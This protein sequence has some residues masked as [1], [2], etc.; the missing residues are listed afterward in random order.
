MGPE[1]PASRGKQVFAGRN[2]F[3]QGALAGLKKVLYK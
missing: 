2:S 1:K 3:R